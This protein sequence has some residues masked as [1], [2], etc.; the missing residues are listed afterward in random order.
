MSENKFRLAGLWETRLLSPNEVTTIHTI[1]ARTSCGEG[2][3]IFSRRE[4]TIGI[5]D[6]QWF[7]RGNSLSGDP[8][9]SIQ[10][11][12]ILAGHFLGEGDAE[13]SPTSPP[14]Q[15]AVYL[16]LG[17]HLE[18]RRV[19]GIWGTADGLDPERHVPFR[20]EFEVSLTNVDCHFLDGFLKLLGDDGTES[21]STQVDD[22]GFLSSEKK[23]FRPKTAVF[24]NQTVWSVV[25]LGTAPS[26]EIA[27]TL[28][29]QTEEKK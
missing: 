2:S 19:R 7:E 5:G 25:R 1:P 14:R 9:T 21:L 6:A 20:G 22:D 26:G 13:F 17:R 12:G 3:T 29:R 18:S 24:S 16:F 10:Y 4:T 27:I 28:I 23:R 11:R 8:T 15:T